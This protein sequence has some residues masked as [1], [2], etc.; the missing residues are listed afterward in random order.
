MN[1]T[2]VAIHLTNGKQFVEGKIFSQPKQITKQLYYM[3]ETV[4][5]TNVIKVRPHNSK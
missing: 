3:R 1:L 4:C 5:V 2:Q